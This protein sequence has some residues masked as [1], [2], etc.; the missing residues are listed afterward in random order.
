MR[1]PW[2]REE[3]VHER[4][5]REAED[6]G[7]L[8]EIEEPGEDDLFGEASPFGATYSSGDVD[9]GALSF[10]GVPR[11]RG[12]WDLVVTAEAPELT[13]AD[14][15]GFVAL[16]DGDIYMDSHLPEGDVTPLAEAIE[17]QI[18]PPYRCR[19][20]RQKGDL[21]AVAAQEIEVGRFEAPGEEIELTLRNGEIET[22]IDGRR[23][24]DSVPE[25]E[26]LGREAADEFFAHAKR[27]DDDIW[28]ITIH[29]I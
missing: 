8:A 23:S 26:E 2:K 24:F 14:E 15:L 12:D 20:V 25:L 10:L 11:I 29:Q 13:G 28:E 27:V 4:L 6:E 3:P 1:L 19:G 16:E 22:V 17:S 9:Q 5:R 7:A 21:W 18:E